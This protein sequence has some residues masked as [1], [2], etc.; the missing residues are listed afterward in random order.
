[1]AAVNLSSCTKNAINNG[2]TITDVFNTFGYLISVPADHAYVIESLVITNRSDPGA[3]AKIYITWYHSLSTVTSYFSFAETINK[4]KSL[5]AL[6]GR[7]ILMQENDYIQ[8]AASATGVLDA[9]W[10]G[11]DCF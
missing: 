4:G 7:Q 10:N 1:M 5:N 11:Y 9:T 8:V 3:S 6:R 2:T